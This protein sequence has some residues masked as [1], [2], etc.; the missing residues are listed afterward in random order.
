MHQS[1]PRPHFA[2]K[3]AAGTP[4]HRAF[5]RMVLTALSS[6]SPR[7]PGLLATVTSRHGVSTE[8]RHRPTRGL[9]PSVGG[10]GPHD[11]AVRRDAFV[12]AH[13]ALSTQASIA[14]R[15]QRP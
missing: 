13:R 7:A 3:N 2:K 14:S 4:K 11:L 12:R 6:C 1:H 8:V 10:S 15:F 5:L 9:D